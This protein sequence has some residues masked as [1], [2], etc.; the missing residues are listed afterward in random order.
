M[1]SCCHEY[2]NQPKWPS[3]ILPSSTQGNRSGLSKKNAS[4]SKYLGIYCAGFVCTVCLLL[5]N[6]NLGEIWLDRTK[7]SINKQQQFIDPQSYSYQFYQFYSLKVAR[8]QQTKL[9]PPLKQN[10][11]FQFFIWGIV[12]FISAPPIRSLVCYVVA[13]KLVDLPSKV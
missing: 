4:L 7:A 13:G 5:D 1:L 8:A 9:Q 12:L 3:G 11:I 10:K 2:P 6:T